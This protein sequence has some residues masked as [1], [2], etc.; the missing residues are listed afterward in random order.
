[1]KDTALVQARMDKELKE[2]AEEIL[3]QLGID[4]RRCQV[5]EWMAITQLGEF[6]K[7]K[8]RIKRLLI[9]KKN[10]ELIEKKR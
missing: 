2:Q 3:G 7:F 5:N 4:L 1:M 8:G 6:F 9:I 10:G